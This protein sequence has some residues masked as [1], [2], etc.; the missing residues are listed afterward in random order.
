MNA[1]HKIC[2]FLKKLSVVE[3]YSGKISG[4]YP[5]QELNFSTDAIVKTAFIF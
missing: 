4:S 1:R 3:S 5:L 2:K